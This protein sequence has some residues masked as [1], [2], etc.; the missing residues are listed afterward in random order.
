MAV[1]YRYSLLVW[2]AI[3][4]FDKAMNQDNHDFDIYNFYSGVWF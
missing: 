1:I 4:N 2:A 3:L